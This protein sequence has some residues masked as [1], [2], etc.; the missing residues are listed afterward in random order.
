MSMPQEA[1]RPKAACSP[2][3]DRRI[4]VLVRVRGC[5]TRLFRALQRMA[6]KKRLVLGVG[7]GD[8]VLLTACRCS[9]D[10]F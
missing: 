10:L 2:R 4:D 6:R 7:G 8:E 5:Q 3:R 1:D 9:S